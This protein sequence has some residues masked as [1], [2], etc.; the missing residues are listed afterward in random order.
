MQPTLQND[1]VI[2]FD[3][4]LPPQDFRFVWH[5]VQEARFRLVHGD[6]WI[7]AFRLSDGAPMWSDVYTSKP[8][9]ADRTAASKAYPTGQGIDCFIAALSELASLYPDFIGVEGRDWDTFFVRPYLYPAGAGLSWHTDGRQDV[10]CAFV[11]YAHPEW[12][13]AWGAELLVDGSDFRDLTYPELEMYDGERRAPGL[14][15]DQNTASAAVM[16][17]GAGTY[18]MPRPNRL[19]LIRRG[20]LHRINPVSAAAGDYVRSSLTGFFLAND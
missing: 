10:S 12:N 1:Q 14:H 16:A 6:G 3:D 8:M 19:A 9:H 17:H 7:K 15:L 18:V 2:V 5:F 20:V 4:F 13:A 11:F